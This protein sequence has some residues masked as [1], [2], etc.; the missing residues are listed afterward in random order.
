MHRLILSI[1]LLFSFASLGKENS[2]VSSVTKQPVQSGVAVSQISTGSSDAVISTV[3][4]SQA[5]SNVVVSTYQQDYERSSVAL[6]VVDDQHTKHAETEP[7]KSGFSFALVKGPIKYQLIELVN[8]HSKVNQVIWEAQDN[9]LWPN[10]YVISGE[11]IEDVLNKISESYGLVI[12]IYENEV[13]VIG[14]FQK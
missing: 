8:S 5:G 10:D 13:A 1:F 6:P 4:A 14:E 11:S 3:A 2:V 7:A 9:Y 12:D